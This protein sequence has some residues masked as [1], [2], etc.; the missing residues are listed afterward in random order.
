M[1]VFAKAKT[2]TDQAEREQMLER[3]ARTVL[4]QLEKRGTDFPLE[5]MFQMIDRHVLA[6]IDIFNAILKRNQTSGIIIK[7]VGEFGNIDQG[8]F[9]KRNV[10]AINFGSGNHLANTVDGELI[11][12]PFYALIL[13]IALSKLPDWKEKDELLEKLVKAP[14]YGSQT[15]GWG[16]IKTPDGYEYGLDLRSTPPRMGGWADPLFGA[17]RNDPMRGNYSRIF[18]GRM[19]LKTYGDKHF[20]GAV[21]TSYAFY[22]MCASG[23]HTDPYGE[24]GFPP[25]NTGVSFIGLPADGPDSGPIL[26]RSLPYDVI[27]DFVEDN[28]RPFDW[29]K[30]LPNPA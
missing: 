30:F 14:L 1:K 19:A 6:N 4:L 28:P 25:N 9:D 10:G 3:A 12:G 11:E 17:V 24:R 20:F 21:A 8:G 18:N 22:H 23:T 15:M 16:T 5:Q 27:K 29:E 13:R 2:I 7:G 26:V